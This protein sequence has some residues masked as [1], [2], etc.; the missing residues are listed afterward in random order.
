MFRGACGEQPRRSNAKWIGVPLDYRCNELWPKNP[1]EMFFN[2]LD[3]RTA[4]KYL[5]KIV[6]QAVPSL[7]TPLT[8]EG[9]CS[10][11]ANYLICTKGATLP[12]VHQLAQTAVLGERG[13]R[14]YSV[15]AGH[16]PMLSKPQDVADVIDDIAS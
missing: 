16:F 3:D 5:A 12:P 11:P 6:Y 2:D 1:R 13:I 4:E 10:V 9:Y 8:Y 7:H 14:T 15:H